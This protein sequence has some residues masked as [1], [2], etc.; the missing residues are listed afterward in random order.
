V[1]VRVID[2]RTKGDIGDLCWNPT[3]RRGDDNTKDAKRLKPVPET[4]PEQG[5]CACLKACEPCDDCKEG[6]ILLACIDLE[7]PEDNDKIP[8]SDR[9][10]WDITDI[11]ESGRKYIKPIQCLCPYKPEQR[12]PRDDEPSDGYEKPT[13]KPKPRSTS[14]KRSKT[15]RTKSVQ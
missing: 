2:D 1:E 8:A 7:P 12:E 14:S 6:W 15:Q 9:D 5:P 3:T 10:R 11:D 4:P 13:P